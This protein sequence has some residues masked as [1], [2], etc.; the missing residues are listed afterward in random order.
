MTKGKDLIQK[1]PERVP[2]I[3]VPG[4]NIYLERTKF[5]VDGNA[6]IGS[7]MIILRKYMEHVKS[8]EAI[9]M[10]INEQLI[11]NTCSFYTAYNEHKNKTDDILY[12]YLKKELTFGSNK[13]L[14]K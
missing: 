2:I 10:F 8:H 7:F 3:C 14:C 4:T 9:F 11:P 6:T 1:Y 12:I 13:K 5:L